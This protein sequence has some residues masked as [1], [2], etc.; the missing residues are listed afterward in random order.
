MVTINLGNLNGD[1][2]FQIQLTDVL[3]REILLKNI[4]ANGTILL[5]TKILSAGMYSI[6]LLEG[7]NSIGISKLSVID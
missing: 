7:K 4:K 2:S 5:D 1:R 3:G 6:K